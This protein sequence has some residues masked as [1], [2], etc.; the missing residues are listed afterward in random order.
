MLLKL[1]PPELRT[2]D[3]FLDE[4]YQQKIA[5]K[6]AA[7]DV[8]WYIDA[9]LAEEKERD[10]KNLERPLKCNNRNCHADFLACEFE[11]GT[12]ECYKRREEYMAKEVSENEENSNPA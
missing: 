2:P 7:N 9:E 11:P 6:D 1:A 4:C 3:E 8:I 5:L 10:Y 12:D